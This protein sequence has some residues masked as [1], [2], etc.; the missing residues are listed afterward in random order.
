M[1]TRSIWFY[2]SLFVAAGGGY[3]LSAINA[4]SQADMDRAIREA[5]NTARLECV[6][7]PLSKPIMPKG[8]LRNSP[9][10]GL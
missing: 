5:V 2:V 6:Q 3:G 8:V 7:Q 10:G 4:P 1:N 9:D